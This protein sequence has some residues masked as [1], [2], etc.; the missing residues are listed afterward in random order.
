ME[1]ETEPIG[2]NE[3][4]LIQALDSGDIS[5]AEVALKR[6]ANANIKLHKHRRGWLLC[7]NAR[8][9]CSWDAKVC[10]ERCMRLEPLSLIE[11]EE[12]ETS[13]A[14]CVF[15]YVTV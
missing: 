1:D 11:V 13:C 7:G 15:Q 3:V 5:S 14:F 6:G 10:I 8:I 4:L 2:Q 12:E 9:L